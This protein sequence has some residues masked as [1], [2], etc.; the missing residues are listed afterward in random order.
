[1]RGLNGLAIACIAFVL[2]DTSDAHPQH[3]HSRR[4]TAPTVN[5]GYEIHQGTVNTTGRYYLFSNIPYS[6][7]P[8]GDLRFREPQAITVNSSHINLGAEYLQCY[9]AYPGWT[10]T[11]AAANATSKAIVG[12][13]D[14]PTQ[15]ESCLVLDVYVPSDVFDCPTAADAPVLVWIHGGGFTLGSKTSYGTPAGLVAKSQADGQAGTIIVSINY[16]LGLFGWLAGGDVTPNLGLYDQRF[17]LEWIQQYIGRFGG[18]ANRVTVMGE[19]AGASSIVHQITAYGGAEP[20]PFQAAIP[21]SPAFQ[22]NIDVDTTY[23]LTFATATQLVGSTVPDVAALRLLNSSVLAE[24]NQAVVYP[25]SKGNFNFGPTPDGDFVPKLPQILL[26][27]GRFDQSLNLLISH[28]SNESVTFTPTIGDANDLRQQ[29]T[30]KFTEASEATI[31]EILTD[32]YPDVSPTTPWQTEFA[33][34]VQLVSEAFFTCTTAYLA[35]A[36]GNATYNYLFAYPPGYHGEDLPYTFFNGDTTTL[37]DGLP[38]NADLA[39]ALQEYIVAFTRTGNPNDN[40]AGLPVFPRYGD[41]STVIEFSTA[42]VTTS[43]DDVRNSRC[44]W[45]QQAIIDGRV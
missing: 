3:P 11:Q 33:R 15:T 45:W 37:D 13:F 44:E 28:C 40:S 43:V 32:V 26:Y 9:Q 14:D 23:G 24:L 20:V 36:K 12:S 21:Q 31:D 29:L 6:Q 4:D 38:V 2:P 42:G 18:S 8:I 35:E 17:A 41:D 5:L 10:L 27:E 39:N 16:R 30:E 25:A 7:Q 34:A 19:S 1:M 22:F